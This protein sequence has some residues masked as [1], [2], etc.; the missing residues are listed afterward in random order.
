MKKKKKSIIGNLFRKAKA[1]PN[2]I[3]NELWSIR[4]ED[5]PK[6]LKLP[7]KYLRVA[8][9]ALRGFNEDKVVVKASALTYYTLMSIVP[10]FAMAFGIA[11]GFG[12]EKYL[13]RQIIEQFQGQEEVM[14]RIIE[15][16]NS[17]LQRT[18]G[19]IIAGLGV[20]LLFWSVIKVLSNIEH[21]FNDIWQVERSRSY[22][23]KFTDYITI[24]LV[25][26][27]LL[28]ASSSIQI[29]LASQVNEFAANYSIFGYVSP[30]ILKLLQYLHYVLIWS[31]F[32]IL[33]IAMPNTKVSPVSGIVAGIIAGTGFILLQWAYVSLQI[34]VSRYNAIYGSFAALPL[35]LIWLQT[36]WLIVLFGAEISF[37]YQNV[38]MYEY[39]H[40]TDNISEYSR[41]LLLLLIIN[42]IVKAF[43]NGEQPL[44][45][46]DLSTKLRVPQRLM[47]HLLILLQDCGLVNEV[48]LPD[49]RSVAY[50]PATHVDRLTFAYVEKQLDKYGAEI[51]PD[52]PQMEQVKR[53][54]DGFR[55]DYSKITGK[56]LVGSI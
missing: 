7:F 1:I 48:N 32:S 28:L 39:E 9:L 4:L 6:K 54:Y 31:L 34:G 40:E 14:N 49:K 8:L 26:P 52:I 30:L 37:A 18:G 19:G 17:L 10:I 12:F 36:S 13:E 25:A 29:Y 56:T 27:I 35:F 2:F 21:A 3:A 5:L 33:F 50:Q 45:G 44:S 15:F 43:I 20:V 53:V 23:R 51:I 16:A 22:L 46:H 11:K 55:N 47:T 42:T 41:K 24:M 38:D